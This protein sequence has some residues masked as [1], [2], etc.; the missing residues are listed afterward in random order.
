MWI[1]FTKH[2]LMHFLCWFGEIRT[3]VVTSAYTKKGFFVGGE[4]YKRLEW[5]TYKKW[6]MDDVEK[7]YEFM[8]AY[9]ANDDEDAPHSFPFSAIISTIKYL[10]P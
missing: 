5:E 4:F 9:G 8:S 2:I 3:I 7:M 6:K 1:P 10:L